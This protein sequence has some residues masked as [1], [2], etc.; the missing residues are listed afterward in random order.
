MRYAVRAVGG[1]FLRRRTMRA[2]LVA[3]SLPLGSCY[4]TK[5][6]WAGYG[7][8]YAN[9]D[10]VA[11]HRVDV[12]G[13]DADQPGRIVMHAF[14]VDGTVAASLAATCKGAPWVGLAPEAEADTADA[15]LGDP[16]AF[17]IDSAAVVVDHRAAPR[18]GEQAPAV[19]SL[20]V[21]L[22]P[23][24][25]GVVVATEPAPTAPVA[26]RALAVALNECAEDLA[27]A[28]WSR[29]GFASAQITS[30][31]RIV[32]WLDPQGHRWLPPRQDGGAIDA[33]AVDGVVPWPTLPHRLRAL[34]GMQVELACRGVDDGTV[35]LRLDAR[36][37]WI[38]ARAL[39]HGGDGSS[40]VHESHWNA[41]LSAAMPS[42]SS[43]TVPGGTWHLSL[44]S[45]ESVWVQS[46]SILL[47]TFRVIATPVTFAVDVVVGPVVFAMDSLFGDEAAAASP[48]R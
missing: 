9:E 40:F 21:H 39:R 48:A 28:D 22:V 16:E 47:T 2:L 18:I 23:A 15:L 17:V 4:L 35:T 36:R 41:L 12:V 24:Q 29:V 42:R 33:A 43:I 38:C 32:A 25:I 6:V 13:S 19:M 45:Q 30:G 26:D 46:E 1:G 5:A 8:D 20:A 7:G 31:A 3:L 10:V 11:D 37:A 34:A 44:R 27:D 14:Q